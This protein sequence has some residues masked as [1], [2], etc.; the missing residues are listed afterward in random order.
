MKPLISIIIATFNAHNTIRKC[1][2]S[3]IIQKNE[4]IELILIDGGS[5]DGTMDIVSEYNSHIDISI[6]ESDRGIYDAWNKGIINSNGNW[7]MFVGA[8][9]C[10][11]NGALL[12]YISY[13]KSHNTECIDYICAR[14]KYLN[15]DGTVIKEFGV[16]WNWSQFRRTMKVAHVASLHSRSLF[17]EV[18]L[19]DLKFPICGDYE[20]LLRK[21][22]QL[23]C[24]YL[25]TCIAR[26]ATGGASFSMKALMEA[27][28]IR[29]MYSGYSSLPLMLIYIWQVLLFQ[30]HK[31]LN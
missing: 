9:D 24:L 3:L 22:S 28:L 10:L 17:D 13:L 19:Y 12:K 1:L 5:T 18:G 26:M 15:K 14:N 2:D 21:R 25:D 4:Y 6:S 16:P 7:I 29:R 30:R 11:E 31:L 8:D 27:H 23:R 20:L